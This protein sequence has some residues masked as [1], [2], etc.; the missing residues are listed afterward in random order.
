MTE[1]SYTAW[2]DKLYQ[3]PP[4]EGWYQA[5]DGK[6][7]PEGYGPPPEPVSSPADRVGD[8][9]RVA[10]TDTDTGTDAGSDSDVG[11]RPTSSPFDD[12]TPADVG[13]ASGG[14]VGVGEVAPAADLG[15]DDEAPGSGSGLFDSSD[16]MP[17]QE[18]SLDA[19]G[20]VAEDAEVG[21]RTISEPDDLQSADLG[22][23]PGSGPA[24][25]LGELPPPSF[26]D[27]PASDLAEE[28]GEFPASD[29]AGEAGEYPAS[30][31]AG[32]AGE[33][34]A[35]DL[36]ELPPP[37]LDEPGGED[38]SMPTLA[39]LTEPA[40]LADA[41]SLGRGEDVTQVVD[42]DLPAPS[43]GM[44]LDDSPALEAPSTGFDGP[45][46]DEPTTAAATADRVDSGPSEGFDAQPA[47]SA[48]DDQPHFGDP[49][50][51]G[52]PS[53]AL[54]PPD[55][56]QPP[57]GA[58]GGYD[59]GPSAFGEA[60]GAA[61]TYGRSEPRAMDPQA[62]LAAKP[63]GGTSKVLMVVALGV[64]ALVAIGA[65]LFFAFGG[66]DDSGDGEVA[67]TGPGSLTQPHPRTSGVVVFY[68]DGE[69]DQ[70]WVVEVLEPVQDATDEIAGD[71][72]VAGPEAGQIFA[73]TRIRVLNENGVEGASLDDLQFNA[74]TSDGR[75]IERTANSCSV[76]L[77]DL[78]YTA[79]VGIGTEVEGDV[80]WSIPA[81]DLDG[82]MLGIESDKVA[83]RVHIALQ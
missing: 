50:P 48:F 11:D 1:A 13:G 30:D 10:S 4:P 80:C 24:S 53:T 36:G 18:M 44:Q 40:E 72:S 12:S 26:D 68:P 64:V 47:G 58:P 7:W 28:A 81:G 37:S 63:R 82:L 9:E 2:D 32:E 45:A 77:D 51:I 3:W 16:M 29:L 70:R 74:I 52:S 83:G 55:G 54:P 61:P 6:W 27:S 75:V 78:D 57:P 19:L 41:S 69:I 20:V 22:D 15:I 49:A 17:T 73:S 23:G 39:D 66:D 38:D 67:A 34:P 71:G 76:S 60:A 21:D 33:Y 31:L 79:S 25:D 46:A 59:A 8:D 42:Q 62:I 43:N 35:S 14:P 56:G 65:V 5:T